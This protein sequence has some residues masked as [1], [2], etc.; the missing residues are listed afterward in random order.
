MTIEKAAVALARIPALHHPGE[1]F[2]YGFSTDLLGRLIEVWSGQPLDVFLRQTVLE[3]LEMNDTGFSVPKEKRARFISCHVLLNG[4]LAVADKAASSPFND[5]FEFLSGGG[6]LVST[7]RDYANFCQMLV[8]G[9]QFK[10]RRLLKEDT[11]KLMFTD[12]LNGMAGPF[13]FGF[14]FA[15]DEI[16]LG[17]DE[18]RRKGRQF[19]WGGYASTA[20]RLVPGERLYQIFARQQVPDSNDL[21]DKLITKIY[22]GLT[23]SGQWVE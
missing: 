7:V 23:T 16:N 14:G 18:S 6:G 8:D 2:T 3:P 21:A 17:S 13:Q 10:G 20:F 15:I 9:G 4:K 22:D 11:I 5:G 19:S 12:Q 1:R